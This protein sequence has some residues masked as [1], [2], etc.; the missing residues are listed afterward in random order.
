MFAYE[1]TVQDLKSARGI[2]LNLLLRI[3]HTQRQL[4]PTI[5]AAQLRTL[6]L[7]AELQKM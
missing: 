6:R 2:V 3:F 7:S 1:Y 4:R 5:T